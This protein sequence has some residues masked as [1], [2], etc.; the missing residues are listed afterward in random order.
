MRNRDS[1]AIGEGAQQMPVHHGLSDSRGLSARAKATGHTQ[2]TV[3][4]T[5]SPLSPH[6]PGLD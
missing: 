6:W 4:R 1:P 5:V 3:T 2:R